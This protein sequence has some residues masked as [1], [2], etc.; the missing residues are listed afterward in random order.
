MDFDSSSVYATDTETFLNDFFHQ[1]EQLPN[2]E[3]CLKSKNSDN[4]T[5]FDMA[6]N[7]Y[8][9]YIKTRMLEKRLNPIKQDTQKIKS[10]I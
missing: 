4:Q 7:Q 1:L 3:Q 5:P 9:N 8:I 6:N 2:F 10:K